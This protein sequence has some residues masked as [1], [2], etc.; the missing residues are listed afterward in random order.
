MEELP[1]TLM[2]GNEVEV[3]VL[4]G[5]N[6]AFSSPS[7]SRW[8]KALKKARHVVCLTHFLD[9]T[10]EFADLL[11]PLA[12]PVEREEI[13][14]EADGEQAAPRKVE[15][16]T[17]PPPEVFSPAE[18]AFELAQRLGIQTA[19]QYISLEEAADN[20]RL[21]L[22]STFSFRFSNDS[23]FR[24]PPSAFSLSEGDF[25]LLLEAPF[26]LARAEGAR[27]PYLITTLA[28]HLREWWTTWMEINP[29]TAKR[30]GIHDKEEVI[31]EAGAVHESPI[32]SI[33]VRAR[34]FE[35]VPPDAICLPLGMGHKL[36]QFAQIEGGNPME[37]IE[38]K[39]DATTGIPLWNFQKV[40]IKKSVAKV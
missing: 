35:G 38:Y 18:L 9:E 14:I 27:F 36:G 26:A 8:Q 13:Y 1:Q 11:L 25:H 17:S 29:E 20:L 12:L 3:V 30:L 24:L 34:L 4:V 33:Q 16:A 40:R 10:S 23:A 7:P 31:V 6:P 39:R 37:L 2:S 15:P 5:V 28:P 19:F 21:H 22:P 32:G